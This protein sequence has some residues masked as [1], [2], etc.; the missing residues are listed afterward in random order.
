VGFQRWAFSSR[1]LL[2]HHPSDAPVANDAAPLRVAAHRL[3]H[4]PPRRLHPRP[5]EEARANTTQDTFP[6]RLPVLRSTSVSKALPLRPDE[7]RAS[8]IRSRG[9]LR[10]SGEARS[11]FRGLL[12]PCPHWLAPWPRFRTPVVSGTTPNALLG[13]NAGLRLLQLA[14]PA[15][16]PRA[17]SNL[18]RPRSL[19]FGSVRV[20]L[21]RRPLSERSR[22]AASHEIPAGGARLR[23]SHLAVTKDSANRRARVKDLRLR[24]PLL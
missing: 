4:H 5:R 16:T 10:C 20:A 8:P 3:E 1:R 9:T 7:R 2:R 19:L 14:R 23:S 13:G 24:V 22:W 6:R 12:W 15:S 17:P 18:T 21:S 11:P